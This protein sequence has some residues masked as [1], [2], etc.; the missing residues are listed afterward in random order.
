VRPM[1]PPPGGRHYQAK[2]LP[3]VVRAMYI[4]LAAALG[5]MVV[6]NAADRGSFSVVEAV[7]CSVVTI[8]WVW[9]SETAFMRIGLYESG[10]GYVDRGWLGSQRV[11]IDDVDRFEQGPAL[12]AGQGWIRL[13]KADGSVLVLQGL[14]HGRRVVWDGGQT[15]GIVAI[16]NERLE[17]QR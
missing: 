7:I 13:V 3:V 4:F 10:E 6:G 5:V 16:L 17:K 2:L 15:D 9:W 12:V 11:L 14:A 1:T 8:A